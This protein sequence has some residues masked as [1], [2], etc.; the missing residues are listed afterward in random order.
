MGLLV[1]QLEQRE[2]T[3]SIDTAMP[4]SHCAAVAASRAW[5]CAGLTSRASR[6][7]TSASISRQLKCVVLASAGLAQTCCGGSPACVSVAVR[8]GPPDFQCCGTGRSNQPSAR[9][10]SS[11]TA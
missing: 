10:T 11:C 2:S 3:I 9:A 8:E 7:A 6:T 4:S 1:A 5:A